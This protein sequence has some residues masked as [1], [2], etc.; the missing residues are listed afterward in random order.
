[1]PH[2]TTLTLE[3]DVTDSLRRE[4]GRT[5]RSFKQGVNDAL[6]AGLQQRER[7]QRR[8]FKVRSRDM[9][10]GPGLEGPERR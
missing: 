1:M 2:R 4:V 3:D 5:G 8:P 9:A 6:R 7:R 10:L